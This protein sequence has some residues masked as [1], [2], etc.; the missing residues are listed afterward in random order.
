M[1]HS[2][3]Q[4]FVSSLRMSSLLFLFIIFPTC[5][6]M[7]IF[8]II[9]IIP[10]FLLTT[11]LRPSTPLTPSAQSQTRRQ[12]VTLRPRSKEANVV[13][14]FAMKTQTN[15][16]IRDRV[17]WEEARAVCGHVIS[18]GAWARRSWVFSC[19]QVALADYSAPELVSAGVRRISVFSGSQYFSQ[20]AGC[21]WVRC[22]T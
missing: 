9:M 13:I 20:Q 3:I 17:F 11:P 15:F 6:A 14:V 16:L 1:S 18:F 8:M 4:E 19:G 2:A 12:R 7:I 21:E 5:I 22:H 10:H